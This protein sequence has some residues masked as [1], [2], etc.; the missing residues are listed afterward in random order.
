[1]NSPY[2]VA[3]I[4]PIRWTC[5]KTEP[6]PCHECG[7]KVAHRYEVLWF[8]DVPKCPYHNIV[9]VRAPETRR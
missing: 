6:T 3:Q 5:P 9:M 7:V 2:H 1:M 8:R 4:E